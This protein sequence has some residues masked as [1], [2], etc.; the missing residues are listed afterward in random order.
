MRIDLLEQAL[1]EIKHE[2][3]TA[4]RTSSFNGKQY[5]DGVA[6]KQALIR[7]SK[8]IMKIHEVT[9]I[10]LVDEITK[11]TSDFTIHPP[12]G[13]TAPELSIIGLLK[14]KKQDIVVL[15]DDIPTE[16]EFITEGP[17]VGLK[18]PL[19]K[20][21]TEKSIVIG[22][23]SQL[24]SINKN[25]DTLMERAFAETLNLR[26]RVP[27]LVMGD[28]YLLP[29]VEYDDVSM[30]KNK[31]AWKNEPVSIEK[32]IRIF[33]AISDRNSQKGDPE[34]YKYEKVA[35]VLADFRSNPPHLF[36]TTEDL[37]SAGIISHRFELSYE[38]LSP[39]H[40]TD[41]L[42]DKYFTRHYL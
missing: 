2:L 24:S 14:K 40:F 16:P 23:R 28:V 3:E 32:F 38:S 26:L 17:L 21:K 7:S 8:L 36:L 10:S 13:K 6:A 1:I 37:K 29:V 31:V 19:G 12:I 27:D 22:V 18:D 39:L 34:I 33:R 41:E 35:L 9:K 20:E 4:I 42:V 30:K 25:F 11:S 15:F 5:S